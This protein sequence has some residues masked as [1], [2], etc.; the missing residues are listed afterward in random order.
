MIILK[1]YQTAIFHLYRVLYPEEEQAASRERS[2]NFVEPHSTRQGSK[3]DW[4][5]SG[6]TV[7]LTSVC[8]P[9]YLPT[10]FRP[11]IS[12]KGERERETSERSEMQRIIPG[13]RKTRNRMRN[14]WGR[15]IFIQKCSDIGCRFYDDEVSTSLFKYHFSFSIWN[16]LRMNFSQ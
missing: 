2:Q 14:G 10:Y 15:R 7:K 11:R 8:P 9:T 4:A 12:S 13:I 5:L 1:A 16:Y 3:T 6:D